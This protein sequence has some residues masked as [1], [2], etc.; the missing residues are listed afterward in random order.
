M[1]PTFEVDAIRNDG[2]V[3]LCF[4][5]LCSVSM[6]LSSFLSFFCIKF[7]CLSVIGSICLSFAM[8]VDAHARD[9]PYRYF[10]HLSQRQ[11]K[12][13]RTARPSTFGGA[14]HGKNHASPGR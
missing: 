12:L 9:S 4:V 3:S 14:T 1:Q 11:G 10:Q 6:F 7:L 13:A 8:G 2:K 5:L